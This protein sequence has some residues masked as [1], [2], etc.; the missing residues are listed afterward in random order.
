M[1]V[2]PLVCPLALLL[3]CLLHP[4]RWLPLQLPLHVQ[5]PPPSQAPRAATWEIQAQLKCSTWLS[6]TLVRWY[7]L[8]ALL[9]PE[10]WIG[11]W[12]QEAGDHSPT[13]AASEERVCRPQITGSVIILDYYRKQTNNNLSRTT[14]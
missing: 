2:L 3:L 6:S 14:H 10:F 8:Q 1:L 9:C 11:D 12:R 13:A 7:L 5:S 4:Y